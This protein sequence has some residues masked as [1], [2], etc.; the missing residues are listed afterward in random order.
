MVRNVL[1][2]RFALTLVLV[3]DTAGA[4]ERQS[5]VRDVFVRGEPADTPHHVFVAGGVAT[6]LRFEKPCDGARTKLLG[7]EGRFEPLLVGGKKVVLEPLMDVSPEDRFLLLV[8]LEDGTEVP[9]TVTAREGAVDHQVNVYP[10]P[11]TPSALRASLARARSRER[12]YREEAERYRAEKTSV[13]HALA[14]LLAKGTV[15]L[16][17]FRHHRSWRFLVD[18]AEIEVMTYNGR[19]KVGVR[20]RVTNEGLSIPWKLREVR[21]TTASTSEERP[22]ALR[23]EQ[24]EIAR[25]ATGNFAVV[26]DEQAFESK[27][28]KSGLDKLVLEV[29]RSDG[30]QQV[31]VVL[32]LEERNVRK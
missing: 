2:L 25:G 12:H 21:L 23:M 22:F 32:E 6:V 31:S 27:S 3:A 4:E 5:L 26:M 19:N 18:G 24:E 11:D 17:P 10:D 20:F 7:W 15:K 30:L 29:F 28:A 13:D 16:T 14:A 9:F 8:T 1:L